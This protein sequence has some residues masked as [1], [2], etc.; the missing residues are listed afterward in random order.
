MKNPNPHPLETQQ[1]IIDIMDNAYQIKKQKETEAQRL[2]DSI[3]DFVL[4][5]LGIELPGLSIRCVF[6]CRLGGQGGRYD[7]FFYTQSIF[8]TNRVFKIWASKL[9]GFVEYLKSGFAAEN[10][11]GQ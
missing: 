9:E 3:D 11:T 4:S 10:K 8:K 2:L 1:Q 6:R 5:E 7:L